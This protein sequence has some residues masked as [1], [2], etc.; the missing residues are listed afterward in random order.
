M[1][2]S[3]Y[4]HLRIRLAVSG[5]PVLHAD[6]HN[7]G[8]M[9]VSLEAPPFRTAI[10]RRSSYSKNDDKSLNVVPSVQQLGQRKPRC[11]PELTR[12][13]VQLETQGILRRLRAVL[14]IKITG[15]QTKGFSKIQCLGN[16]NLPCYKLMF[17]CIC[18]ELI[19]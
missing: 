4:V 8:P 19:R 11:A 14:E 6:V 16:K 3:G 7:S 18:L 5:L 12:F 17:L 9:C 10:W 1:L 13:H 15:L 2:C